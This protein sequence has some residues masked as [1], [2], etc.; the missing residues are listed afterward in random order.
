MIKK[1]LTQAHLLRY[2]P[3]NTGAGL[4]AS[5]IDVAQDFLLTSLYKQGVFDYIAI[6]GGTSIR[7]F[8]AGNSGRFSTDLDFAL[9]RSDISIND[10][11]DLLKSATEQ[12][13]ND[14]FRYKVES[15]RGRPEIVYESDF[16]G[17]DI[18]TTKIDVGAPSWL[19]PQERPW[20]QLPI[21]D[22][23]GFEL[24]TIKCVDLEENMSEKLARLNRRAL[25]RDMYDLLW[26][27]TN[28]PYSQFN[29]NFVRK[30]TV[31]KVWVDEYGVESQ[32]QQWG[33]TIG[34][35]AFNQNKW[36][37]PFSPESIFD[38]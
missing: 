11:Q 25:A 30:L 19:R 10:A 1:K 34:A 24:P 21:H 6:K 15:R 9:S 20:I 37:T 17:V 5:I 4:E 36:R 31:L 8:Y 22:T 2:A 12:A 29:K 16:G 27:A 35:A 7:K 38:E 33:K 13:S 23:Y 26:I 18:L 28:S 3:N 32:N 14:Y